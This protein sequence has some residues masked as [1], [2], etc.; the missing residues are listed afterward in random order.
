MAADPIIEAAEIFTSV[1]IVLSAIIFTRLAFKSKSLSSFQFQL[2]IFVLVW[3]IAELPHIGSTLGLIDDTSYATF[4]ITFH[5][6]SMAAF[7][8][9]VGIKSI[10]FLHPHQT[11]PSN[12]V[13]IATPSMSPTKQ[14][15]APKN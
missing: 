9:F 13:K 10:Q 11:P 7:A 2:S 6:I 5:F 12:P 3:M 8:L 15:G 14:P 1:M 4:G